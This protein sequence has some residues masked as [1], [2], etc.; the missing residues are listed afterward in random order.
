MTTSNKNRFEEK[1]A[2]IENYIAEFNKEA[3]KLQD[4]LKDAGKCKKTKMKKGLA[5][6]ALI[7]AALLY[8]YCDIQYASMPIIRMLGFIKLKFWILPLVFVLIYLIFVSDGTATD[9]KNMHVAWLR[10]AILPV[11]YP[12]FYYYI[13]DNDVIYLKITEL[14]PEYTVNT[15]GHLESDD[16]EIYEAECV[17]ETG[18]K[19]FS[20]LLIFVENEFMPDSRLNKIINYY[21][22]EY[23]QD[24]TIHEE[25]EY[26][27]ISC[28]GASL[29]D[30][31]DQD[32][33][34]LNKDIIRKNHD[35][36]DYLE[37]S[38]KTA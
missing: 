36:I 34:T 27:I 33:Y 38:K 23:N 1:F 9:L 35:F 4:K 26:Y 21:E 32:G 13:P 3:L 16:M 12:G 28:T 7:G 29:D 15:K 25:K 11:L 18:A 31:N 17:G 5:V 24:I 20:G 14:Y 2:E 10:K 19:V 8:T 22:K 30:F 6:M 37:T